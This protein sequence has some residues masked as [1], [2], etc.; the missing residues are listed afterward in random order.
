ME[1]RLPAK[2]SLGKLLSNFLKQNNQRLAI[3]S[4]SSKSVNVVLYSLTAWN[5][6]TGVAVTAK[7]FDAVLNFYI[8]PPSFRYPRQ[9]SVIFITEPAEIP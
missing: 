9:F 5:T 4:Q 3:F 1:F 8:V 6:V 7:C 2:K